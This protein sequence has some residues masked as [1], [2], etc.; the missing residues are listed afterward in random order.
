VKR[1]L[2]DESAPGSTPAVTQNNAKAIG[3]TGDRAAI[4]I[5]EGVTN[6]VIG[7]FFSGATPYVAELVAQSEMVAV[8]E[9]V[10]AR[11][12]GFFLKIEEAARDLAVNPFPHEDALMDHQLHYP[13]F[14]S[15][16][17]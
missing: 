14:A 5:A 13:D 11:R 2:V 16:W 15:L 12:C 9:S 6:L 17:G 3:D 1:R 7:N 10:K 4:G 8:P